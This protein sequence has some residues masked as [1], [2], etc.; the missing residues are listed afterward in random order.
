MNLKAELFCDSRCE[1][2]EG[3]F[4]HPLLDRLFWFDILNRTLLS[5]DDQGH[6]VDRITFKDFANCPIGRPAPL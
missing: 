4:W 6:I 5:A 1:L 2:G 3:P